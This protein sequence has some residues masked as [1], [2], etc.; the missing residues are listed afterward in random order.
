MVN[1]FGKS[2]LNLCFMLDY[3]IL[4]GCCNGDCSGEYTYVLPQGSSVTDYFLK[5]ADLFSVNCNL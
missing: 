5:S 1:N 4:N 2:L 3:V